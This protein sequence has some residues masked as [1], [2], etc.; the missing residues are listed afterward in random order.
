MHRK[1]IASIPGSCL[2]TNSARTTVPFAMQVYD[3]K[4]GFEII[5]FNGDRSEKKEEIVLGF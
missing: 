3:N 1:A 2:E 4:L 5:L